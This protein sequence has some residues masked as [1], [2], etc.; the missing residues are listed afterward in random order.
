M[1]EFYLHLPKNFYNVYNSFRPLSKLKPMKDGKINFV[2]ENQGAFYCAV[3]PGSSFVYQKMR[4]NGAKWNPVGIMDSYLVSEFFWVLSSAKNLDMEL[5]E[6][7]NF[8]AKMLDED[9]KLFPYFSDIE[10]MTQKISDGNF[11][12]LYQICDGKAI[13]MYEKT[14]PKLYLLTKNYE[15]LDYILEKCGFPQRRITPLCNR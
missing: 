8:D 3:K 6:Y 10:G 2:E 12:R 9:G 14:T 7:P 11:M 13:A 5:W 4:D 15:D 1:K